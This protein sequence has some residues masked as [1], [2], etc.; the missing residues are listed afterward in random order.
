MQ[1]RVD[2]VGYSNEGTIKCEVWGMEP[3]LLGAAPELL[4]GCKA[5]IRAVNEGTVPR[6][7][8]KDAEAV[9]ALAEGGK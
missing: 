8:L 7:L 5:L 3:A 1:G 2:I 4:A 9:V 6:D